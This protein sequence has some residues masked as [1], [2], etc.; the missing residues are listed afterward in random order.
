[1]LKKRRDSDKD[2]FMVKVGRQLIG[3]VR[4]YV[5]NGVGSNVF[6]VNE[7]VGSN[8][9]TVVDLDSDWEHGYHYKYEIIFLDDK[10]KQV[11]SGSQKFADEGDLAGVSHCT[12]RRSIII[13]ASRVER[14]AS[15]KVKIWGSEMSE[16]KD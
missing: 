6:S 8:I 4:F 11:D 13:P 10:G 2:V 14:V 1:L 12:S 3:T 5:D 9:T 15:Y 7:G 16:K